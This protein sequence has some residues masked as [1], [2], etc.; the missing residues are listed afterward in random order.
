MRTTVTLDDD[1]YQAALARSRATGKP[2]GRVVSDMARLA[3]QP[4]PGTPGARANRFPCFVVAPDTPPILAA[5][6][7][8]ALDGDGIF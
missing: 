4:A 3:L 2:L 1:V 8:E 5:R 6:V 7:Q